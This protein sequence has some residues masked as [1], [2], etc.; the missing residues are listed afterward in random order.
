MNHAIQA[1]LAFTKFN[2]ISV[3]SAIAVWKKN[4]LL[5]QKSILSTFLWIE[6]EPLIYFLAFGYGIGQFTNNVQGLPYY[7]YLFPGLI[8]GFAALTSFYEGVNAFSEKL[9]QKSV[10]RGILQSPVTIQDWV[11]G[12]IFWSTT[13]GAISVILTVF[14]GVFAGLVNSHHILLL[15]A[16][17]LLICFLFSTMGILFALLSSKSKSGTQIQSLLMLF[18]FLFSGILFPVDTMPVQ[19][20]QVSLMSPL[21]H[22][23]GIVQ[24][25]AFEAA[26]PLLYISFCYLFLLSMGLYNYTNFKAKSIALI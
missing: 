25:V 10:L 14:Y 4:Y 21:T 8:I 7:E 11:S 1:V 16:T 24:S 12:E 18:M 2:R 9:R 6:I 5:V 13:K 22:G 20:Q 23:V 19:A 26:N 15:M 3:V 17:T